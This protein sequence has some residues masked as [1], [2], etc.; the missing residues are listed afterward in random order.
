MQQ[1]LVHLAVL[2]WTI[3]RHY[4]TLAQSEEEEEEEKAFPL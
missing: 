3:R 2:Y 4:I 1:F